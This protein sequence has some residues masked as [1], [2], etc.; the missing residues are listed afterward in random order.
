MYDMVNNVK[1]YA[2]I[3][4]TANSKPHKAIK[5]VNGIKVRAATNNPV[6]NNI[7]KKDESMLNRV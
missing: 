2:W 4:E 3:T 6:L 1:T 5:T 7:Y